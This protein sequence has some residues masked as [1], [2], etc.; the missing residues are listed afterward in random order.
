MWVGVSVMWHVHARVCVCVVYMHSCVWCVRA[1]LCVV[2]ACM[3]VC[4]VCVHAC[5]WCVHAC[6]CVVCTCVHACVWRVHACLSVYMYDVGIDHPQCSR[7]QF[8]GRIKNF[9]IF[10]N[11]ITSGL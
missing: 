2:Y 4:S 9:T 10:S 11:T 7:S 1:R 6:L 8:L 3:L 5:V